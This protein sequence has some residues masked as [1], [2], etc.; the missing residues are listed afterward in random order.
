MYVS[1]SDVRPTHR[2]LSS[3]LQS[4]R[5]DLNYCYMCRECWPRRGDERPW[6]LLVQVL[7]NFGNNGISIAAYS[8]VK[9]NLA[10]C[11]HAVLWSRSTDGIWRNIARVVTPPYRFYL[12]YLILNS[13]FS[14]IRVDFLTLPQTS[15]VPEN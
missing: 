10:H 7:A 6:L 11:Y 15:A 14:G 5:P 3:W 1:M 9:R 12:K 13:N 2:N 4:R 8:S